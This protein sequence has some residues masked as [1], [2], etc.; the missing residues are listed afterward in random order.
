MTQ[1]L[2]GADPDTAGRTASAAITKALNTA[3]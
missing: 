2:T 3:S 1:V